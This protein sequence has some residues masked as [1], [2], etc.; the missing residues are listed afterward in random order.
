MY[1][2]VFFDLDGTLTDPGEGITN[3]VAHAL[4]RFGID[5]PP[6]EELYK[7]IGPPLKESFGVYYGLSEEDC[8]KAVIYY[9]E[10]YADKGVFEN[11]VYEGI[12]LLLQGVCFIRG[13]LFSRR[14]RS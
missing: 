6:R 2:Y 13:R 9:R 3:S 10:H 12:P 14:R 7:F 11:K 4:R 1:K 5:V 8:E